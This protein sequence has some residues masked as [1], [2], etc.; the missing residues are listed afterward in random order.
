LPAADDQWVRQVFWL[1]LLL[2][3]CGGSALRGTGRVLTLV[4]V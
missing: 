2:L 3:V 1:L 4:L